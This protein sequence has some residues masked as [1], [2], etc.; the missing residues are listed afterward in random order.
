[1]MTRHPRR[2]RPSLEELE[3]RLV[4]SA[5]A[6]TSANWSGFAIDT[7]RG[8]VTAVSGTWVVPTATGTG[9]AYSSAWVGIDGFSSS[10]VEQIGTDSD[11]VNGSP[12]YY[13]WYEMYPR[14]SVELPLSIRAGDTV[15]AAV[16]YAAGAFTLSIT[17]VS[18]G[19][20]WRTTQ[21][22]SGVQRSSAEWVVEAPSSTFGLLPLADFGKV[23][24]TAAQA[25]ASGT[26]GP[27]DDGTWA[28]SQLYQINMV[29][30]SGTAQ[31]T[32]SALT[33]SGSPTTSS[34]AVTYA[35]ASPAPSPPPSRGRWRQPDQAVAPQAVTTTAGAAASAT[36]ALSLV[37]ARPQG[38]ASQPAPPAAS[39]AAPQLVSV[40]PAAPAT[41]AA[42]QAPSG[43]GALPGG[44]HGPEMDGADGGADD[45]PAAPEQLPAPNE[46]DERP[47]A[48]R[49]D[50]MPSAAPAALPMILP[51]AAWAA[52]A[53]F[54]ERPGA[55]AVTDTP[56]GLGDDGMALGVAGV[57]LGLAVS[58]PWD[59]PREQMLKSARVRSPRIRF[60][61]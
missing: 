31:D 25:T 27:I 8:A 46:S 10:T 40:V 6:T 21:V 29:S 4:P 53:C 9:T 23:S 60:F 11:L 18:T 24:F 19:Q 34:F 51:E 7:S 22:L 28:G 14:G 45:R 30:R 26:T 35:A 16:T 49:V 38:S 17:D 39:R 52:D 54:V 15:S 41:S 2:L 3:R 48:P 47:S 50:R 55:T 61:Q 33:N 37:G 1:M 36:V 58:S 13:A 32:T 42:L 59:A 44:V 12:R 43:Q 20:S 57:L 56:T 5:V